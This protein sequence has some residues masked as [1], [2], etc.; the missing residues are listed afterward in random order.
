M[1]ADRG[2]RRVARTVL[3]TMLALLAACAAPSTY[4]DVAS[5]LPPV[6]DGA[7][8][9]VLYRPAPGAPAMRPGIDVN[10]ERV[11]ASHARG[12]FFVD[13]P[14][15]ECVVSGSKR[16]EHRLRIELGAGETLYVRMRIPMGYFV[17]DV[18]CELVDAP[19]ALVELRPLRYVGAADALAP[20]PELLPGAPAPAG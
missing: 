20:P 17:S 18:V 7:G 15:G 6:P 14:P 1:R 8:R 2:S 9:L 19:R 12:F 11:G 13:R 4:D 5:R 16:A 10:G 3:S